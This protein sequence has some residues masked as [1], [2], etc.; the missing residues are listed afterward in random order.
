MELLGCSPAGGRTPRVST[1]AATAP[2]A[3]PAGE[4][5][6]DVLQRSRFVAGCRPLHPDAVALTRALMA[7][8]GVADAGADVAALAV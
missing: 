6:N 3:T 1:L 8:Y 5:F 2:A 4:A 7:H